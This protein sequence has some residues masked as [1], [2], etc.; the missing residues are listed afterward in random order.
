MLG[1]RTL[2]NRSASREPQADQQSQ[3]E[4]RV[5]IKTEGYPTTDE[6]EEPSLSEKPSYRELNGGP[7]H[8]VSEHMQPLGEA[9]NAR[10][11]ARVKPDGGRKSV[12]G[13]SAAAVGLDAQETPEGTPAP[14]TT[15]QAPV[16]TRP[17]PQIVVDDEQDGDYA[18]NVAGKKK[19]R[20]SRTRAAKR[21][22]EATPGPSKATSAKT[23]PPKSDINKNKLYDAKK[24]NAVVEAAKQRARDVGKPDLAD[25]VNE[26]YEQSLSNSKLTELLEAILTQ[27]ATPTQ[28]FEFQ[29]FARAARKKIKSAKETERLSPEIANGSKTLPLRSPSKF[30]SAET[31][32]AAIPSTEQH[33]LQKSNTSLKV[34]SPSKDPSRRRSRQ[35][36]S[37]S[38]SPS[39]RRSGSVD[40]DS[41]LTDLTSNPD[42]D[43]DVDEPDELTE[44]AAGPSSRTNGIKGKD[45]AAERGSL[46]PPNRNLKRSSADADLLEDERDRILA[47]KKQK[48]NET[49]TRDYSYEES[50]IRQPPQSSASRLRSQ[51]GK[52]GSLA[53]TSMALATTGSRNASA[54]GSRGVSTD[55]DS[56]LSE[57]SPSS[58]RRSTPHIWKGRAKTVG[59]KAKTKQS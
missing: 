59:K 22:S 52:N 13:K 33:H 10:V 51:R 17:Q 46:A 2:R 35:G 31:G 14:Q 49:V 58:S 28:T 44:G 23:K 16:N 8:V 50:N 47:S 18:P 1:T 30:T 53:P 45:H 5:K 41:S 9:P 39:K 24:L 37:M 27:S 56:P 20:S 19:E 57:L 6:W 55:L 12:L 25:A 3:F 48:L 11:K 26:I 42:E 7:Y 54:R 43:M 29:E 15:S 36:T 40:S 34:K 38:A 21:R 4:N 32:T